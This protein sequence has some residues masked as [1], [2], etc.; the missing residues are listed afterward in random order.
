MV[1]YNLVGDGAGRGS[2]WMQSC[3]RVINHV[4]KV[5]ST[6]LL[7]SEFCSVSVGYV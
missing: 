6:P 1:C 7:F 3:N 2:E 4:D 5:C